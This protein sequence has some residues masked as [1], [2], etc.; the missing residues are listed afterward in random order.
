LVRRLDQLKLAK[1]KK[2][3]SEKELLDIILK[4]SKEEPY[5]EYDTARG[6][7]AR[8]IPVSPAGS[9]ISRTIS[10]EISPLGTSSSRTSSS[11]TSPA[12]DVTFGRK[13]EI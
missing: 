1:A 7:P 5:D 12:G 10:A 6:S 8:G 2:E 4:G 3:V 11:R 13:S 9:D